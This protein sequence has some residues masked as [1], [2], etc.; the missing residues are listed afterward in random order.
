[1]GKAGVALLWC[2][3]RREMP[4]DDILPR[5]AL[6]PFGPGIPVHDMAGRIEHIDRV[7][8]D[9]FDQQAETLFGLFELGQAR[10]ELGRALGG[11]LFKSLIQPL[12]VLFRLAPSYHFTLARLVKTGVVDGH[13]SLRRQ[14]RD[15]PFGP[16]GENR[17]A[18]M[19]KKKTS[20]HFART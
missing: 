14:G 2:I 20:K 9:T 15:D 6:D 5:I 3:E 1:L 19:S 4:A 13:R 8:G 10:R 11:P 12:Q 18:G 17:R 16:F 7:V